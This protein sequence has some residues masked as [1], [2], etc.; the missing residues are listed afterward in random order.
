MHYLTKVSGSSSEQ[1]QEIKDRVISTNP[2]LEAFGNAKTLR[3]NNSSRFVRTLISLI[4]L[5]LIEFSFIRE[6]K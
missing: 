6:L 3:N 4:V 5:I 2:L 1:V